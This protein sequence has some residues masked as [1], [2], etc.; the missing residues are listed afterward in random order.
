MLTGFVGFKSVHIGLCAALNFVI[1]AGLIF[2]KGRRSLIRTIAL[3]RDGM[4]MDNTTPTHS[5]VGRSH[6]TVTCTEF[7]TIKDTV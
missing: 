3:M 6:Y 1:I 4:Y 2:G 5:V 7:W